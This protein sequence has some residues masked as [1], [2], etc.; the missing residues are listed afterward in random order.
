MLADRLEDPVLVVVVA[1]R[2][3]FELEILEFGE[4]LTV[5]ELARDGEGRGWAHH[6]IYELASLL[7]YDVVVANQLLPLLPFG[8]YVILSLDAID[9]QR[10]ADADESLLDKIH[11][12]HLLVFIIQ[13]LL[14]EVKMS[15]GHAH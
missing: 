3:N 7:V 5:D 1:A 8:D 14:V 15:W 10:E 11:L 4:E 12:R 13:D 6:D 2:L 9:H